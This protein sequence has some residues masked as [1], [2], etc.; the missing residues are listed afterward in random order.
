MPEPTAE[1]A[2][3]IGQVVESNIVR[4]F[5]DAKLVEAPAEEPRVRAQSFATLMRSFVV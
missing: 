5:T 1:G 3:E 4:D 2:I